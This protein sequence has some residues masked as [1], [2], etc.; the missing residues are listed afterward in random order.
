MEFMKFFYRHKKATAKDS[1]LDGVIQS[2]N[3]LAFPGGIKQI[4]K[5][6]Q[7]LQTLLDGR[8]SFED[9]KYTFLYISTIYLIAADKSQDGIVSHALKR[10]Q[11]SLDSSAT[12]VIFQFVSKKERGKI[13]KENYDDLQYIR[14]L[15]NGSINN[16]H[17]ENEI[18]NGYG[19]FGLIETNP[20]PARGIPASKAYLSQLR[21]LKGDEICWERLG[22]TFA[23][24]IDTII[25][26][27]RITTKDG[28]D[29]GCIYI[30]PYQHQ[31]STKAPKGFI[32]SQE[33]INEDKPTA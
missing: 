1:V 33:K 22:S 27:Y 19:E 4:E 5:E 18:P 28:I 26:I 23:P 14:N 12:I 6:T 32:M 7:L 13:K 29:M 16:K 10:P 8:Y 24:N 3:K 25:D 30:N 31:T 15:I 17:T 20:V 11:N 2:I 21:T 9:V